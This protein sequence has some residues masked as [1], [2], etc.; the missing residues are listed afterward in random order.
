MGVLTD[1]LVKVVVD[2]DV[3]NGICVAVANGVRNAPAKGVAVSDA[4]RVAN[5]RGVGEANTTGVGGGVGKAKAPTEATGPPC[6]EAGTVSGPPPHAAP[7]ANRPPIA[8]RA[9]LRP[10]LLTL[11]SAAVSDISSMARY[12]VDP[13]ARAVVAGV[14]IRPFVAM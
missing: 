11:L 9:S 8:A 1:R 3:R 4:T 2:I 12:G 5:S 13:V 6:P 7:M 10:I 14:S